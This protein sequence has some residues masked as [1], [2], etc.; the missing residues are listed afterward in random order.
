MLPLHFVI[1]LCFWLFII[2][3]FRIIGI[4]YVFG[5]YVSLYRQHGDSNAGVR[6]SRG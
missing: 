4:V 2:Y 3:L 6:L 1:W 5:M